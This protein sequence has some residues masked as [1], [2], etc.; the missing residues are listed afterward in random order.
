[1]SRAYPMARAVHFLSCASYVRLLNDALRRSADFLDLY[2]LFRD[3]R[4]VDFASWRVPGATNIESLNGFMRF[5]LST[6]GKITT[7]LLA[8]AVIASIAVETRG[9]LELYDINIAVEPDVTLA[10]ID[11]N[12]FPESDGA[13][14]HPRRTTRPCV[15]GAG[16]VAAGVAE[17]VV[18]VAAAVDERVAGAA[19]GV[20]DAAAGGASPD[21]GGDPVAAGVSH[22]PAGAPRAPVHA[23]VAR[24]RARLHAHGAHP[25]KHPAYQGAS[26]PVAVAG[27]RVGPPGVLPVLLH[28]VD[29]PRDGRAMHVSARRRSALVLGALHVRVRLC[30]ALA[31][32]ALYAAHRARRNAYHDASPAGAPRA[33]PVS[34]QRA[35]GVA[36][37]TAYRARHASRAVSLVDALG[38][39]RTARQAARD[40]VL[41]VGPGVDRRAAGAV[42]R[43]GNAAATG[44]RADRAYLVPRAPDAP[45]FRVGAGGPRVG[46]ALAM[47]FLPADVRHAGRLAVRT[48]AMGS[49]CVCALYAVCPASDMGTSSRP[50]SAPRVARLVAYIAACTSADATPRWCCTLCAP[51][52][53][54]QTDSTPMSRATR[55]PLLK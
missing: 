45:V 17:A 53:L 23:L 47:D 43:R 9:S 15:S 18:G 44:P 55:A 4:G 50:P 1:M 21:L 24:A 11:A 20:A 14:M 48:V 52:I 2:I 54:L 51:A 30:C 38:T 41:L 22:G 5:T 39:H 27:S 7:L 13:P 26:S 34:A 40:G 36:A 32:G 42:V 16:A 46:A 3:A 8:S 25:V 35:K 49:L 10:R 6:H 37:A 29:R 19:D 31:L 33:S 12:A 28:I